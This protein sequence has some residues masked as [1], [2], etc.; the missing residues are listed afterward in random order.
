MT[1]LNKT[2]VE[3]APLHLVVGRIK[4]FIYRNFICRHRLLSWVRN[5]HGDE[6]IYCGY[7]RTWCHC[8][9]CGKFIL[10][11]DYITK[12][13]A[14]SVYDPPNPQASAAGV[15]PSDV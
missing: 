7:K 8:D 15:S 11:D 5:T 6:I 1:L 4:S 14:I 9:S 13:M 12:E 3:S 2:D 10:I